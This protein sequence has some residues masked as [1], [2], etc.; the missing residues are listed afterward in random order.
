MR[1]RTRCCGHQERIGERLARDREAMGAV[2]GAPF[3]ACEQVAGHVSSQSLVRYRTND[4]SV[5]VAYGHRQV[6]VVARH[7]VA[8]SSRGLHSNRAH[9][10]PAQADRG[11]HSRPQESPLRIRVALRPN[12]ALRAS[13]H[14]A[15]RRCAGHVHSVAGGSCCSPPAMA[16]VFG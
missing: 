8:S 16:L 2:L 13:R 15:A 12:E 5:P 11:D 14:L 9:L 1:A 10:R 7:L 3:E 4:Y 6:S